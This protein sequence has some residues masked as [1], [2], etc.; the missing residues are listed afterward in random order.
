MTFNGGAMAV[1][2]RAL[3]IRPRRWLTRYYARSMASKFAHYPVRKDGRNGA[4]LLVLD[5]RWVV[6]ACPGAKLQKVDIQGGPPQ[7]PAIDRA[8]QRCGW[9]STA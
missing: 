5:S 4:C 3:V 6:F 7:N 2:R 8:N 9:N 1:S